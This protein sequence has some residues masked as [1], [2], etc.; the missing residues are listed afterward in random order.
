MQKCSHRSSDE[1]TSRGAIVIALRTPYTHF[2]E[3]DGV[4][5]LQHRFPHQLSVVKINL[6]I[7]IESKI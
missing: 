7:K 4:Y 6:Q 2:D 1:S 3:P 5:T